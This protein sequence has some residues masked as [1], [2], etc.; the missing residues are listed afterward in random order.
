MRRT[1]LQTNVNENANEKS[2]LNKAFNALPEHNKM[3]ALQGGYNSMAKEFSG[4]AKHAND[5]TTTIRKPISISEELANKFRTFHDE[6][7]RYRLLCKSCN[8][9]FGS[10]EKLP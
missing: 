4:L 5:I 1:N 10:Y 2:I 6:R 3:V 9:H 7:A 8:S